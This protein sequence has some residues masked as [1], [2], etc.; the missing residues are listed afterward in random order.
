M[1][2]ETCAAVLGRLRVVFEDAYLVAG[3]LVKRMEGGHGA[4]G[5]AQVGFQVLKHKQLEIVVVGQERFEEG[6]GGTDDVGGGELSGEA[7]KVVFADAVELAA[8]RGAF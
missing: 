1:G 5:E 7:E 3:E 8:I 2:D 4:R 6:P